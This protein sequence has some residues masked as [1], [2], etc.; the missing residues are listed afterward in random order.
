M[1]V[2]SIADVEVILLINKERKRN[3]EVFLFLTLK[4]F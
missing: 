3:P 1:K 4:E 2:G